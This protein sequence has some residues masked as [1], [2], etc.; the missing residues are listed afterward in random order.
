MGV[1]RHE[2]TNEARKNKQHTKGRPQTSTNKHTK[3]AH[4]RTHTTSTHT[5]N[6]IILNWK[7]RSLSRSSSNSF[8]SSAEAPPPPPENMLSIAVAPFSLF[9]EKERQR[10]KR[11][12]GREAAQ[13]RFHVSSLSNS[14]SHRVLTVN[15]LI[16]EALMELWIEPS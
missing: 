10:N 6:S 7:S 1:I 2:T 9:L 4:V 8:S 16:G 11:D 13:L 12:S 5:C 14:L 15:K 3:Q